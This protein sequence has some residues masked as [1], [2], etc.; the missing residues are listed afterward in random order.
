MCAVAVN[1]V[2]GKLVSL[3]ALISFVQVNKY[4]KNVSSSNLSPTF[5]NPF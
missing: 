4:L 1:F 3:L 5:Y 2:E